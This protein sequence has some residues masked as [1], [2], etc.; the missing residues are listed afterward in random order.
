MMYRCKFYKGDYHDRQVQANAD[1][2]VGYVEHHFNSAA[3]AAASYTVVITGANASQTSRNWG[4]WYAQ[5]VAR[6]FDLPVGGDQGILVGGYGGRGDFNLRFTNMPAI[7][8][9]PLFVSNPQQADWVRSVAGQTRLAS[10]LSDSIRR[11]FQ[12]GGLIGFSVGHKYKRS[13]PSDRGAAVAGGGWEADYAEQVLLK[14]K[15]MLEQV[16]APQEERQIQIVAGDK[17]LFTQ[18]IDVD[19]DV[20]WD[21]VR[22]VLRIDRPVP[23]TVTAPRSARAL[24]SVRATRQIAQPKVRGKAKSKARG[25]A[26]PR[27]RRQRR[28]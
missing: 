9:E 3:S 26:K 11:F 16:E 17:V 6:E 10:I 1:K 7:L 21:S 15:V 14:A 23:A 12:N 28:P 13:S 18:V 24:Q 22:G 2:C 20:T 19:A 25:G 8:L 5:A 27:A 4:R